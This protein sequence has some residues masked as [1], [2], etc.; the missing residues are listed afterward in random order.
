MA[1]SGGRKS[2]RTGP[3]SGKSSRRI[4]RD[5]LRTT[6]IATRKIAR[7]ARRTAKAGRW[8]SDRRSA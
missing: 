8:S 5:E 2:A 7:D 3:R 6:R 4:V 1:T